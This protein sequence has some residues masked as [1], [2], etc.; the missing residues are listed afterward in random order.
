M[1]GETVEVRC[2]CGKCGM[3]VILTP[4]QVRLLAIRPNLCVV[5]K[6]CTTKLPDNFTPVGFSTLYTTYLK[7][8]S[9]RPLLEG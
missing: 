2:G 5:A 3:K 7:P 1:N 6:E 4:L 9:V 8:K